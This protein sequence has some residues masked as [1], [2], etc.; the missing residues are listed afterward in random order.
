MDEN[1][2]DRK[3]S[4]DIEETCSDDSINSTN[5]SVSLDNE[6]SDSSDSSTNIQVSNVRFNRVF[7][8]N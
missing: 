8:Y 2:K 5:G 1:A 6:L 7:L 3:T 4:R